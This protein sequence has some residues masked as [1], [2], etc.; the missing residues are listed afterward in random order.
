M[1]SLSVYIVLTHRNSIE[2]S[3]QVHEFLRGKHLFKWNILHSIMRTNSLCSL[4]G[5]LQKSSWVGQFKFGDRWQYVW[6]LE[7]CF[8]WS[9]ISVFILDL[10]VN[11]SFWLVF[12]PFANK[13]L[14][15]ITIEIG[16]L[17]FTI[18]IYP[19]TFEMI[20]IPLCKN[21]ISISLTFMPLT[22]IYVSI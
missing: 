15:L 17:A 5:F 3:S 16:S 2:G 11:T 21:T 20:S 10:G 14:I 7:I 1:E 18:I 12:N 19:V 4:H 13:E 8:L 6:I 9:L 22:F